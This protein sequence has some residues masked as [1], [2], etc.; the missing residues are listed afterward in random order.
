VAGRP[1]GVHD[2]PAPSDEKGEGNLKQRSPE[3]LEARRSLITSTDLPVILGLS[4]YKSEAT[5][6]REKLGQVEPTEATL[7]MRVGTALE[8]VIRE[9]Y[10]RKTG[11]KLRRFH[12]MVTHPQLE[13]AAASPDWRRQGARYLVEGKYSTARR[14]EGGLP[15]DVEAQ[16]RWAMGCTG[17]AIGDVARLDGRELHISEPIEHDAEL[18]DNLVVAA[19]DFRRRMAEG[20]PFTE[21]VASIKARYPTD[22]GTELEAD[23]ELEEAVMELMRLRATKSEVEQA[24]ERIEVAVKARMGSATRLVGSG[25]TVT[26]KRTRDVEQTDWRAVADGLLR[27]LPETERIALVGL[28][29][30]VREGFRPFRLV[31]AKGAE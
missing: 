12:G 29:S 23:A 1:L 2:R 17:Y 15:Q 19:T 18:F 28:H 22:D 27:Q 24:C 5:L 25:W 10:E 13:W 14:W 16:V 8:P 21:D 9:E 26:W 6:A 31:A 3:W 7:V 20:G 4:P 11:V 30:S